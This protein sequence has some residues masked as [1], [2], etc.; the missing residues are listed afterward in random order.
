MLAYDAV[1]VGGGPAGSTCAR[2]LVE[3]GLRVLVLDAARF[4]RVKLCAGW[5]SDPVWDVLG[6]APS[7]Y[8]RG[9]WEWNRCHV[10]FGDTD[11]TIS[12]HGHFIRRYEFDHWLLDLCGAEVVQGHR[13]ASLERDGDDWVVDGEYRA[14]ILIGAGGT[15]C[16][17]ARAAFTPKPEKPVGVQEH[18]FETAREEVAAHRIGLDGEPELLLHGDLRGYSWN[19][20]KT[21]WIN[22]GCGTMRPRDVRPA[23]REA[24]AFF[25]ESGHVPPSASVSLDKMGGH[26]YYLFREEHLADAQR[27]GALLVG[28]SLGVSHPF[29]AEGILP[30][31]LSARLAAEAVLAGEARAYPERLAAHPVFKDYTLLRRVR[32]LRRARRRS[33]G[34]RYG[35]PR[36]RPP[37]FVKTA[38]RRAVATGF[39]WMFAGKPL[40]GGSLL[41]RITSLLPGERS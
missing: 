33:N 4:P 37:A 25:E 12:A 9:L 7:E 24:R 1:V 30:S 36:L 21:D 34:A 35:M 17:V 2:F 14:P 3:G 22:V 8:T 13:V 15:H 39:A 28:D 20:P 18:E 27:D 11:H 29:T 32:N 38:S 26:S 5:V 6:I 31:V 19:I 23:W 40:P 10:R 41:H 16:P